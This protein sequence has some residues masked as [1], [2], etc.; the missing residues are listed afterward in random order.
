MDKTKTVSKKHHEAEVWQLRQSNDQLRYQWI[1]ATKERG[2]YMMIAEGL[3][4]LLWAVITQRAAVKD[5]AETVPDGVT[6]GHCRAM[7]LFSALSAA[8]GKRPKDWQH[9][10][11]ADYKES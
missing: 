2:D 7:S 4:K 9:W 1:T 5:H 6:C 8:T 11:T 3:G 10:T